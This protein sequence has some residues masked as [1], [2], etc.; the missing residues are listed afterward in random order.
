MS[1][2]TYAIE[3]LLECQQMIRDAKARPRTAENIASLRAQIALLVSDV[4]ASEQEGVRSCLGEP[5]FFLER[6]E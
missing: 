4:A 6:G 5:L 3:T 1:A 2:H